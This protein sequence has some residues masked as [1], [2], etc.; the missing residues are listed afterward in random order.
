LTKP[1]ENPNEQFPLVV[2]VITIP[3]QCLIGD[4][5]NQRLNLQNKPTSFLM[6][7]FK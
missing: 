4:N 7:E 1:I 6:S 3:H 2:G 5:T